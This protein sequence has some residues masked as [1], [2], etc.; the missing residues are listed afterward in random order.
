MTMM[1]SMTILNAALKSLFI[2]S[3]I[4]QINDC[5]EGRGYQFQTDCLS[6]TLHVDMRV[7]YC[8]GRNDCSSKTYTLRPS[9]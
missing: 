2:M 8:R 6:I 7:M 9:V 4:A 3:L 1:I 5:V